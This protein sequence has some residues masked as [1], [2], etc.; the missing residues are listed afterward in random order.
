MEC[1]HGTY[2]RRTA[3]TTNQSVGS[4]GGDDSRK[5]KFVIKI[6][7]VARSVVGDIGSN[8]AFMPP[9]PSLIGSFDEAAL[10]KGSGATAQM[11]IRDL[12]GVFASSILIFNRWCSLYDWFEKISGISICL[13]GLVGLFTSSAFGKSI[14]HCSGRSP[15]DFRPPP[16]NPVV[17]PTIDTRI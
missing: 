13:T 15:R 10:L 5:G 12:T 16:V 9:A 2:A 17:V 8:P 1:T 7:S 11:N 3:N 14:Q 6:E 4:F